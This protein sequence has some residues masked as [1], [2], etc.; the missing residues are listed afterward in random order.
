VIVE[1][2]SYRLEGNV[3]K[4]PVVV[5]ELSN[6]E[7]GGFLAEIPDLPGCMADGETAAEAVAAVENAIE[8][9]IATAKEL[10]RSIPEPSAIDK[11]SGK[12]VQRV[13]KSLH[14]KLA[15][16]AKREGVSLNTLTTSLIA[17]GLGKKLVAA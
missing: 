16:E 11:Y 3:L 13:P 15:I 6:E 1:Q 10:N 8:E 4:Y 7:G 17:E 9:W 2:E 14:M 5:R 12:W